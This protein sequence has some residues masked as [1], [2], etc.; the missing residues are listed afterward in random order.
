MNDERFRPRW[1]IAGTTGAV[2]VVDVLRAFTTAAYAFDAGADHILLV[3]TVAEALDLK[4]QLTHVV[5][6]GEDGGR[7]P[8]G[9]DLPNS[10]VEVSRAVLG[11]KA[12][13][14][15]TS[16]GT[17]GAVAARSAERLWCASLVCASA[18]AMAVRHSGLGD[19]TYVITGRFEDDPD[20][21]GDDVVTARLIE[22]ARRGMELD[23][24]RAAIA[25]A[26]SEE[27]RRTLA[28]GTG[29]VHPDDI[30]YAVR[31]DR[32]DFAME[33]TRV[34]GRLRLDAVTPTSDS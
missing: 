9:F 12:L 16:A 17:R 22:R 21:G 7:R 25:V 13:V 6:A 31:V 34:D 14:L 28:E 2:V 32:F 4:A 23:A 18:T 29:H 24:E 3:D 19:P 10:P 11:G 27:A 26:S 30:E 33:V 5:V 15:R 20:G 8:E 1:Q